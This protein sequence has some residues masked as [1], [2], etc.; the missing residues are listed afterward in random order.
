MSAVFNKLKLV[1]LKIDTKYE[2]IIYLHADCIV[3]KLEGFESSTRILVSTS[4]Q[5]IIA[6]VDVVFSDILHTNEAS[7]SESAW[8]KLGA[9]EG[10]F[11]TV[12]HIAPLI[13]FRHVRSK[14]YGNEIDA[15]GFQEIISDI[16]LGKYANIHISSF[17]TACSGN[18]LNLNE[19]IY[20][21]QSMIKTG[22]EIHWQY[23]MVMD[24]HSIGGL[25][26]NRTT[27]I[28]VSIVATAGLII[29]KTS[30][31]SITS[32]AGTADTVEVMTTVDLSIAKIRE[33]VDRE[34]GCLA[35]G[36]SLGLSPADDIIIRVERTLDLDPESQM[37]ASVLSKKAA[38][39]AT[40][41]VI[42]VP[43]GPSAKIRSDQTFLKLKEYFIHVGKALGLEVAILRTDGSQPIGRGIGP[44][45][46]AKDILSVLN[47]EKDAPAD[48]KNKSI[49]IAGALIEFG[50]KAPLG[51]GEAL[52]KKILENGSALKKFIAIC[53]AQGGFKIPS[54]NGY[55]HDIVSTQSGKV[56]WIDN[57]NLAMIAKLAGAPQDPSAGIEFFAKLG[58]H[59]EKGQLLYRIHAESKGILEY[60]LAYANSMPDIIKISRDE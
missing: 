47:N 17:I 46:E 39:G 24:K 37:I 11:I 5:S 30:S 54:I 1:Q 41:I 7:L 51:K 38:I 36:G 52:A 8:N 49:T 56:I 58:T 26:G 50:N 31:R 20:L 48:L 44:A 12:S 9:K 33:V 57:R 59:V 16:V 23:P 45:L 55:T 19:I 6:T 53:E 18:N 14:I 32:P 60:S 22:E 21:T 10:D 42:E 43:V 28:V 4:N 13:S 35:W 25:P 15:Q 40:H 27:P 29:P 2:F 3:C 34:G